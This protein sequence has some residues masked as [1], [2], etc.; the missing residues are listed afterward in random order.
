MNKLFFN[1]M[2][3]FAFILPFTSCTE[4][5]PVT[6]PRQEEV[7]EMERGTFAKGAD[8]SWLTQLESEGQG[9]AENHWG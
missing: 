3:A 5:S 7:E 2:A 9:S 8:V 4:D 6:N 1:I